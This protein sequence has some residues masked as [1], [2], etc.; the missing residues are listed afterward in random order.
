MSAHAIAQIDAKFRECLDAGYEGIVLRDPRAPYDAH[1]SWAALKYKR[2]ED[3]EWPIK[4]FETTATGMQLTCLADGP[5]NKSFVVGWTGVDAIA[6]SATF[7][8]RGLQGAVVTLVYTTLY[9]ES[10][11]PRDARVKCISFPEDA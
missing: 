4:A 11:I 3:A 9:D 10:R 1:R 7:R 5:T 8:S 2:E 6:T